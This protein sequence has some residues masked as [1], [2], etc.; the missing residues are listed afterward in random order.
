MQPKSKKQRRYRIT[1]TEEEVVLE[2]YTNCSGWDKI[3]NVIKE[4]L[5]KVMA[6]DGLTKANIGEY[7][8]SSTRE[9]AIKRIR[10]IISKNLT[11]A[12]A[13]EP[14]SSAESSVAMS[15]IIVENTMRYAKKRTP[16][17]RKCDKFA[18]AANI[19]IC[20]SKSESESISEEEDTQKV[21]TYRKPERKKANKIR[22]RKK[23]FASEAHKAHTEMCGK[24]M[25]MMNKIEKV[26]QKFESEDE[27]D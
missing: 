13:E 27:T 23:N 2:A 4:R 8:C 12:R 18:Q 25:V 17:E 1:K 26:L 24:A 14:K 9:S 21:A 16:E 5:N 19:E 22:G 7:Y 6:G 11:S 15:K 20:S 10:R 3:L